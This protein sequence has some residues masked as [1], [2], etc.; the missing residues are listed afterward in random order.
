MNASTYKF[1]LTGLI[2][3]LSASLAVQAGIGIKSNGTGGGAY[4]QNSSWHPA[5]APEITDT[6]IILQNDTIFLTKGEAVHTLIIEPGGV[7]DCNNFLPALSG[8]TQIE[9]K[10]LNNARF[11]INGTTGQTISSAD[12]ISSLSL[13][14]PSGDLYLSGNL[15]ISDSLILVQG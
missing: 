14:K 13:D 4:D 7:L 3:L 10:M 11:L 1:L 6:V 9:G 12:T 5:W 2:L 8:D 15:V